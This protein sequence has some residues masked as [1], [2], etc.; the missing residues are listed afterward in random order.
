ME[1]TFMT[2]HDLTPEA[3]I[4]YASESISDI[5]DFEPHEVIGKS[6]FECFH[7]NDTPNFR[8]IH[9]E[10]V[11]LEKAA[12]I[13]Y[14][15]IKKKD[16][17]FQDC[18]CVFTIVH[19]VLVSCTSIYRGKGQERNDANAIC[20]HFTTPP[21]DPR[22]HMLEHL[23]SKFRMPTMENISREP[24]AA[25]I[26]NRFTRSLTVMYCTDAIVKVLGVTKEY[27]L[28]KS[29]YDCVNTACVRDAISCIES[30]KGNDSIAYIRFWCRDPRHPYELTDLQEALDENS[31]VESDAD[32]NGGVALSPDRPPPPPAPANL[33]PFEQIQL[34][35]VISCTSDGL[36]VILR[37]APEL[38]ESDATQFAAAPWGI[39][40]VRPHVHVPD[41]LSPFEHGPKAP[42]LQPDAPNKESFLRSI[43]EVAV[44]AWALAGIN[45]H[46]ASYGKG[47]A[48]AEA[49]PPALPVYN[50]H[51]VPT[52]FEPPVCQ[53][54]E[55]WDRRKQ[56]SRATKHS[57]GYLVTEERAERKRR[58]HNEGEGYGQ[59]PQ[60]EH[61]QGNGN[62]WSNGGNRNGHN[63]YGH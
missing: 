3:K 42:E 34:E 29:F 30:A 13:H 8:S 27:L 52:T 20:K 9:S 12:V 5:L 62:G 35:A 44:F 46:I 38:S 40:P 25:L 4:M 15:R 56:Q 45:G 59:Q 57:I 14:A 47:K 22:Y 60:L 21:K 2:I 61:A 41:A 16:G 26:L 11:Y 7:D 32:D 18:E 33:P 63:G 55:D 37:K 31:D 17:Q 43:R 53:A 54:K 39:N 10:S 51:G 36:V 19:D 6:W 48:R 58:R 28:N 1:T 24:R 23:S 49:Q 50:P